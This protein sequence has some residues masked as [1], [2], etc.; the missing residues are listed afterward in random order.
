VLG[1]ETTQRGVL[2]I[3]E[4][5][6]K[7]PE[8]AYQLHISLKYIKPAIWRRV[9]VTDDVTVAKL[10]TI[11]QIVMGWEDEHL[12]EFIVGGVKIGE[13]QDE[14]FDLDVEN[15]KKV[16]LSELNLAEKQ[17][18]EYMYDFGD[19]WQHDIKVETILPVESGVKYPKCLDGA[20]ACPPEDCGSYP[21]YQ[22]LFELSK[23]PK[24]ELDE[25]ELERLEWLAGWYGENFDF[26]YF[27]V[28][29]TN[30]VLWKKFVK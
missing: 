14:L 15:E 10:H 5:M 7:E 27:S 30:S 1:P 13:L 21:G 28:D 4:A 8:K 9:L 3:K 23:H 22:Q 19:S 18:F 12:H 2:R 6:K 29:E 26:E 25:D 20:M 24:D 17:K 16:R 11:I